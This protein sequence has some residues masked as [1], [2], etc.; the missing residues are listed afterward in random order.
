MTVRTP[1]EL[2]LE[3]VAAVGRQAPVDELAAF[4]TDDFHLLE[5]PNALTPERSMRNRTQVLK[6]LEQS[7]LVVGEQEH[8]VRRVV[9]DGDTVVV[10]LDW[11]ATSR[12]DLPHWSVGD[13]MKARIL[14]VFTVRDG[15]IAALDSFDSYETQG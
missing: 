1:R 3:Y 7:H 13:R 10:E 11:E 14:S 8:T 2:V 9:A 12:M 15:L 4:L 6:G 5:W